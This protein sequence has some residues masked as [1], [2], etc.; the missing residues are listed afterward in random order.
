MYLPLP[1]SFRSCGFTSFQSKNSL[2]YRRAG[3]NGPLQLSS[4]WV[5]PYLF[6]ISKQ[7][8]LGSRFLLS[9][10]WDKDLLRNLR[11]GL[12]MAACYQVCRPVWFPRSPWAG[13]TGPR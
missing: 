11:L 2:Q 5:D 10:L 8:I 1:L 4:V 3:D 7:S 13:R 12:L 9:A 6:F